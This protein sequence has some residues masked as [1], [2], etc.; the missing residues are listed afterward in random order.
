VRV[1]ELLPGYLVG[2]IS[3]YHRRLGGSQRTGDAHLESKITQ[4]VKDL[5]Q[6]ICLRTFP[7][8]NPKFSYIFC[9]FALLLQYA[10]L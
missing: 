8:S 10:S 4:R 7:P 9:L 3:I 6:K 1:S 5:K 2:W